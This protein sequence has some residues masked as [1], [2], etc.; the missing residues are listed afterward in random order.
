MKS[1]A[2]QMLIA[3]VCLAVAP[4]HA[5][6]PLVRDGSSKEKAIILKQRGAKAVEE[7]MAWMRKLYHYTPI[8]ATRDMAADAIRQLK[9]GKKKEVNLPQP[10]SHAIL[11]DKGQCCSVWTFKTPR[12]Q[13]EIY[14]DTG[15]S[16]DIPGEVPRQINSR[17]D[18]VLKHL[19]KT[20]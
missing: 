1:F 3:L 16:I 13:R 8:D 12:R 19:P 9:A 10:W 11:D 15:A 18:Y 20:L 2:S 17:I 6:T 14:F 7:E 5:T 4:C